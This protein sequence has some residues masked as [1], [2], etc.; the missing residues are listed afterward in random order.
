MQAVS[1][2]LLKHNLPGVLLALGSSGTMKDSAGTRR[3]VSEKKTPSLPFTND[4]AH[5]SG[6]MVSRLQFF[7]LVFLLRKM[8]PCPVSQQNKSQ[9]KSTS[10][11]ARSSTKFTYGGQICLFLSHAPLG[12]FIDNCGR[13]YHILLAKSKTPYLKSMTT[14]I[15][16]SIPR[17]LYR[18]KL[19]VHYKNNYSA[20]LII[21]NS[22]TPKAMKGKSNPSRWMSGASIVSKVS[23]K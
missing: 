19:R 14:C 3:Q 4:K 22:K 1:A 5:V 7:C 17:R 10:M 13:S 23:M 21:L 12:I 6:K 11:L 18:T 20:R 9:T 8:D 2:V 16:V 15:V